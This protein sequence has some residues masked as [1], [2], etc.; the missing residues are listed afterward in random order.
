MSPSTGR[1]FIVV[2]PIGKRMDIYKMIRDLRQRQQ[3]L[4]RV[5]AALEQLQRTNSVPSGFRTDGPTRRGRKFMDDQERREVS[6]RMKRYWA[7]RRRSHAN[8]A[9]PDNKLQRSDNKVGP[10]SVL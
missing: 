6:E 4:N 3:H 7:A 2:L 1:G 8:S 5:I 9:H 10:T